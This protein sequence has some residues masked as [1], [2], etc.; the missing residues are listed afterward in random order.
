MGLIFFF[1]ILIF[2]T[3]SVCHPLLIWNSLDQ[4]GLEPTEIH[5]PLPPWC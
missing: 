2:E 1:L 5:V 3:G 4:T